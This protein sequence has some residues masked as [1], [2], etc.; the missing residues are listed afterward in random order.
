MKMRFML[1][2]MA[3]VVIAG[4][5]MLA[6]SYLKPRPGLPP[7]PQYN[8]PVPGVAGF[9]PK[10]VPEA[11]LKQAIAEAQ[12][13]GRRIIL[14]VG[15]EWCSWCHILDRYYQANSDLLELR[16]RNFVWLKITFSPDNKNEAF[17]SRFPAIN[18]YPHLFVLDKDGKLLHS[19][20]TA[21]LEE[22]KSYNRNKMQEFLRQWAPPAAG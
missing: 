20:D 8:T 15:G 7:V 19:Q 3:V 5:A 11:D 13:S 18:G 1:A 4:A 17:L 2:G 6:G 21:L 14:D 12:R 22:G 16:D 9:D 10:A